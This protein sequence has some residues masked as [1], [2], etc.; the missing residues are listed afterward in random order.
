MDG[1][2]SAVTDAL[3]ALKYDSSNATEI[4]RGDKQQLKQFLQLRDND[5]D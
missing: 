5:N 2:I 4:I 1:N 3:Y